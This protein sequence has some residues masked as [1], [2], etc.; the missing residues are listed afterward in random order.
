MVTSPARSHPS[1]EI[2]WQTLNS[3]KLLGGLENAPITVVC[4]GCRPAS[5]LEPG[6]AGRLA[7]R[8]EHNP[9]KFS[10]RGIVTDD[11]AAGYEEY[12]ERLAAEANA[13]GYPKDRFE[14]HSLDA[15]GGFAMAVKA[16]LESVLDRHGTR[17]ALVVQHDR[18]FCRQ[19]PVE[20]MRQLYSHFERV[21]TCRYIGFPSGTSKLLASKTADVY[22]LHE[23]LAA[24]TYQLSPS[25][26][27]LRP[28][29]FWCAIAFEACIF[30]RPDRASCALLALESTAAAKCTASQNH[31]QQQLHSSIQ[32]ARPSTCQPWLSTF[33][34]GSSPAPYRQLSAHTPERIAP[35]PSQV[36][37][38][39]PRRRPASP[40]PPVHAVHLR[41]SELSRAGGRRWPQPL[42]ATKRRL[43]RGKVRRRGE[44]K[45]G[46]CCCPAGPIDCPYW[47][48]AHTHTHTHTH[49]GTSASASALSLSLSLSQVWC[50]AAQ[51]PRQ[52]A[53]R[54]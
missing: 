48:H 37:Q 28:C 21:R 33:L 24:R 52:L 40:R 15:H 12:K 16:G 45:C 39:P 26:I 32:L 35:S 27:K 50:R 7:A 49:I 44:A 34:T 14:L 41:A 6:Y 31:A 42:P 25:A 13:R 3:L 53:R 43:Y 22:N 2:V 4:D 1:T 18:A 20:T 54:S 47:P 8:L 10:K 29:I 38:Q 46:Q 19:V 23:L 9:C 11:V 51:P 36:R 5:T 30:G 17:Y